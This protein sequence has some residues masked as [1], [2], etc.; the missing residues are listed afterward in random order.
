M[1]FRY[2]MRGK[3]TQAQAIVRQR[4]NEKEHRNRERERIQ[5]ESE[6]KA[7]VIFNVGQKNGD[8]EVVVFE[9]EQAPILE[10]RVSGSA[11][12]NEPCGLDINSIH[13]W[14]GDI[15]ENYADQCK[16]YE[17]ILITSKDVLNQKLIANW[18][19]LERIDS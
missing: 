1:D 10:L 5:R 14:L 11:I 16:S 9:R 7:K 15:G 17:I 12:A 6:K 8:Y 2:D 13:E 18:G 19:D 3:S 4:D